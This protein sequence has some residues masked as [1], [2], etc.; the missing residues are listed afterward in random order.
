L[1]RGRSV[2]LIA[3]S[4]FIAV[5]CGKVGS[6]PSF[7][8]TGGIMSVVSVATSPPLTLYPIDAG[9]GNTSTGVYWDSNN[10]LSSSCTIAWNGGDANQRGCMQSP[11]VAWSDNRWLIGFP[12][13]YL[14][15]QVGEFRYSMLAAQSSPST[16]LFGGFGSSL[17]VIDDGSGLRSDV[18]SASS[19]YVRFAPFA[20]GDVLAI[21]VAERES[22][23]IPLT[24]Q[25]VR[26]VFANIYN[27]L[28]HEWGTA[29]QLGT[30]NSS[31]TALTDTGTDGSFLGSV[32]V[33]QFCKPS[34]ATSANGTAMVAW[35]EEPLAG[36]SQFS[37]PMFAYYHGGTWDTAT[38]LVT[39]ATATQFENPGFTGRANQFGGGGILG[40]SDST[41]FILSGDKFK[42]KLFTQFYDIQTATT[43]S[44]TVTATNTTPTPGFFR[45]ITDA[46]GNVLVCESLTSMATAILSIPTN[47]D[48]S[49]FPGGTHSDVNTNSPLTLAQLGVSMVLDPNC[50]DNTPST[51]NVSTYYNRPLKNIFRKGVATGATDYVE[52]VVDNLSYKSILGG[53]FAFAGPGSPPLFSIL[54]DVSTNKA[55]PQETW[56]STG[57]VAVAG[58]AY[59][60][61]AMV[62]SSV[63]PL[64]QANDI[65]NGGIRKARMLVGHQFVP[66][67]GWVNRTNAT[68]NA[69]EPAVSFVSG[70][71]GCFDGTDYFECSVRN[72]RFLMSDAGNGLVLFYENQATPS[73][74]TAKF[75]PN[76]LW[77]ATYSSGTGFSSAANI[78]DQDTVCS[79]L[80]TANDT[81]VCETGSYDMV[82]DITS[83]FDLTSA[84]QNLGEPATTANPTNPTINHDVPPIAAAMNRKGQA[85]V[86]YSKRV[87]TGSITAPACG[88][89]GTFV[90][91]YDTFN[92]FGDVMQVD[93]TLTPLESSMH[94]AVAI[95]SKG[96]VAVA[97]EDVSSSTQ[98]DVWVAVRSG[99]VWSPPVQANTAVD[100]TVTGVTFNNSKNSM[101]PSV[102]IND[103]KQVVVTF[104]Y[105][106]RDGSTNRRQLVNQLQF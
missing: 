33:S 20:N 56:F 7:T 39:G 102:G 38:S 96:D 32:W 45:I 93:S 63:A 6:T 52:N 16:G 5:A 92:G 35:C 42:S 60:N 41:A 83:A 64:L 19:R 86:A 26:V 84:C 101:M 25:T 3:A 47:L 24:P 27:G 36:P 72:P 106:P 15:S 49:S 98:K 54:P 29:Q 67:P 8:A 17:A 57:M 34:A 31:T 43:Y 4:A 103:K 68:A 40:L 70:N 9:T 77:Y 62:R 65:T 12:Q 44:A 75:N 58:D 80:S 82:N 79:S 30:F 66:G 91:T 37:Q 13:N 99:G 14:A 105:D 73:S 87:S 59:G 94:P 51:W 11:A 81:P 21:Y 23:F 50:S 10:D 71:P 90:V 53:G 69:R 95:N 76:R 61:F 89:M 18:N 28:T 85:V 46:F 55:T 48:I 78:L 1:G 2:L 97:W 22:A 88:N 104:S 74:A 100:N